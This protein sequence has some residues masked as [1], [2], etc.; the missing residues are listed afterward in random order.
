MKLK[1]QLQ[2]GI[3]ILIVAV[4][5]LSVIESVWWNV[6]RQSYPRSL[7]NAAPSNA[8]DLISLW[9]ACGSPLEVEPEGADMALVRCGTFWPMRSIWL[10]PRAQIGAILK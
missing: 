6:E 2:L 8:N 5:S 1:S 10:V 3:I 4:G 7:V 9:K